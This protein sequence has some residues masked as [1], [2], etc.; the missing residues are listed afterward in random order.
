MLLERVKQYRLRYDYYITPNGDV[1]QYG[2]EKEDINH[3]TLGT[4]Y[5]VKLNKEKII[6]VAGFVPSFKSEE[7]Y[8]YTIKENTSIK[9]LE[10]T[11]DVK[12]LVV[13]K[14]DNSV[15][16]LIKNVPL[17]NF[18]VNFSEILPFNPIKIYRKEYTLFILNDN[19]NVWIYEN[20]F[21]TKLI[22]KLIKLELSNII[23]INL[24][25][26][27]LVTLGEEGR[28]WIVDID[29]LTI[30]RTSLLNVVNIFS[31]RVYKNYR[32]LGT[33]NIKGDVFLH[34][35]DRISSFTMKKSTHKLNIKHIVSAA[36]YNEFRI[37][38]IDENGIIY[39]ID[40]IYKIGIDWDHWEDPIPLYYAE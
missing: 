32:L 27:Y 23:D 12:I 19:K 31:V 18:N 36:D 13:I 24:I 20:V 11:I 15:A 21:H 29:N 2:N 3:K 30:N 25:D 8:N 37:H 35:I 17:E 7:Y 4:T 40:Q 28:V 10:S 34:R 22:P 39:L 5:H 1:Y 38:L 14:N 16:L 9:L 26:K 33:I 6:D